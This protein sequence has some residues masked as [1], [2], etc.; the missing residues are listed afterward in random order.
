ML[1]RTSI[2]FPNKGGIT[3][4]RK[5]LG[6]SAHRLLAMLQKFRSH[7]SE[8]IQ[9][10]N[11]PEGFTP[12]G[13]FLLGPTAV[14]GFW[15]AC[16]FCAHGLAGAGGIGKVMAEWII[17]GHPEWDIWRL[18][19]RRFGSNYN[20]QDYIVARTIETYSKYYDIHYPNEERLSRRELRLSPTYYRLRDLGAQFGDIPRRQFG[21]PHRGRQHTGRVGRVAV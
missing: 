13:E 19:V 7:R 21:P 1:N 8:I 6:A 2:S 18:D 11:G 12:D 3:I 10:L 16:A 20:S 15:V 9:L 17:D 4:S 5:T 14:K